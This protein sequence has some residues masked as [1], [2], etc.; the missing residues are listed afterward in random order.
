MNPR[1]TEPRLAA[2]FLC[3]Y[4]RCALGDRGD[5]HVSVR[6]VLKVVSSDALVGVRREDSP[7]VTQTPQ[8]LNPHS[9]PRVQQVSIQVLREGKDV[10]INPKFCGEHGVCVCVCCVLTHW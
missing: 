4:V 5:L 8:A 7:A 9:L 2:L 1:P 3:V 6:Q 10:V